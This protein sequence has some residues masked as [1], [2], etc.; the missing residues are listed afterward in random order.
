MNYVS[1]TFNSHYFRGPLLGI[2]KNGEDVQ[3]PD[4]NVVYSKDVT[5]PDEIG[6]VF[7]GNY[8]LN[9][10]LGYFKP[11]NSFSNTDGL[12]VT[13]VMNLAELL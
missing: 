7:I 9:T 11:I 6:P 4:G 5:F 13:K 12:Y 2:L 3:L 8:D 1:L 10:P